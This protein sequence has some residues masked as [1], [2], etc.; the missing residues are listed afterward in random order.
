MLASICARPEP[1]CAA[2]G[3]LAMTRDEL[4]H[5][6]RALGPLPNPPSERSWVQRVDTEAK[7]FKRGQEVADSFRAMMPRGGIAEVRRDIGRDCPPL[8]DL[9]LE[10]FSEKP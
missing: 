7:L 9:L 2:G 1:I 3:A 4:L 6:Y 8:F 10:A 5:R